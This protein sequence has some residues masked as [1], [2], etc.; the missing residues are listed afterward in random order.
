MTKLQDIQREGGAI[1]TDL[2]ST[3]ESFNNDS[4]AI[5]AARETAAIYDRTHWGLIQV[6]GGDRQRFLHNQ[7]TNDFNKLKSG[8]GC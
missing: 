5:T 4:E 1:F 8:E 7:T 3:P 6:T 2:D